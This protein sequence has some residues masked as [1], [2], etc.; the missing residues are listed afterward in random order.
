MR[1]DVGLA[2]LPKNTRG[3][4]LVSGR[5][6]FGALARQF[7][8]PPASSPK[9]LFFWVLVA[10]LLGGHLSLGVPVG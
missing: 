5:A 6:L 7:N 8:V 1:K 3:S 9:R 4:M 2:D 10:A